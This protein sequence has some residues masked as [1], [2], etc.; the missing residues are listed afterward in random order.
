MTV[1][2]TNARPEW[3]FGDRLRKSR[4]FAG[5]KQEEM[6]AIFDVSP[7]TISN[8]ENGQRMPRHGELDLARRWAEET[9]VDV[10]WLLGVVLT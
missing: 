5:L 6:A 1:M 9:G 8:W 3:T 7:A 2:T 4:E 10:A